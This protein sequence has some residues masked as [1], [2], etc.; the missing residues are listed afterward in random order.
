[1][2][3]R[4]PYYRIV[5]E[6]QDITSWVTS[7]TV[8]EDDR[9][10]DSVTLAVADPRMAYA[11]ALFEGSA[12]EVDMG[13]AG[14]QEH[15]L[16]LKALVTKV[17]VEYPDDGVSTI[18]L[19]GEDRSIDMGLNER[20]CVW[21]DKKLSEIVRTIAQ[22]YDYA[23]IDV[24]LDPDPEIK[25]R[26][27]HQDG[28]TD[29][30]FLQ[31][32]AKRHHAKCFVEL[33]ESDQ[34]AFYFIPERRVVRARRPQQLVLRYRSGPASNLIRF[35]PSFDAGYLDRRREVSDIGTDGRPVRSP[36]RPAQEA[37]VW[38]L[39]SSRT[40]A[41]D[42]EDG[43]RIRALYDAGAAGK[44][45]LHGELTQPVPAVG[46]VASGQ[47]DIDATD[48]T[49]EAR[50]LGMSATG[51]TPGNIWLRAKSNVTIEGVNERFAG[52]WYVSSVTHRIGDAG[53]KTDF[54]CVR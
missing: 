7:V 43:R 27:L 44:R 28:K 8:T 37:A 54:K 13:Y 52:D 24:Q 22:E 31:D 14:A 20:N 29:L 47:A 48:A 16:M 36:R 11:D 3:L 45:Q 34:E 38:R 12:V 39:D 17:E 50:Q 9:Q 15:A 25:G 46:R 1:M 2:S 51:A 33:D 23:S 53:F 19:K 41:A 10:A 18:T 32:L 40:A 30:A 21:R 42:R 26:P 49:L 5:M 6:G 35:S 4:T